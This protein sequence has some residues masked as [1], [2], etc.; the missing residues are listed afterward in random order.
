MNRLRFLA[1]AAFAALAFTVDADAAY[2][3]DSTVGAS[4]Y[5]LVS[6]H[7]GARPLPGNGNHVV[8]HEGVTWLFSSQE[9]ADAFRASP[10]RYLPA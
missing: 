6:Y 4:G 3:V 5:D 1:L 7:T 9:N 10:A 2:P 8:E